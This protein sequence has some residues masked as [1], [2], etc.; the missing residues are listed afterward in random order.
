MP[1]EAIAAALLS[2]LI[3]AGWNAALKAGKDRL[4][5]MGVMGVGGCLF[6]LVLLA[7]TGAPVVGAWPYLIV[8][9]VV[10]LLYWTALSR[11]YAAGDMSHVYTIA[12]G[13]APALVTIAAVFAARELPSL[14]AVFGIALVSLGIMAVGVSPRAPFK[15]TGWAMLTGVAIATYSLIDALGTRVSG[16]ALT[17]IAWSSLGTFVPI[18]I[19][20]VLRRGPAPFMAA[21]QGR[22][23]KTMTAGAL[24]NAG[25]GIVLWAQMRAPIGYVT[26]L[27]ET[28]VVF[29]AAIAAI[30]LREALTARR[31]AGAVVVALGALLIG[32]SR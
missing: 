32:F 18:T 11:G 16:D 30:I 28:S 29:G 24:S 21:A 10:H 7:F 5:D 4:V 1:P 27:R 8:S 26:A 31:W 3:H 23:L 17:Y 14:L 2:A 12:R 13:S 15:A 22:W 19:F 25:F 6:G 9:S 20:A